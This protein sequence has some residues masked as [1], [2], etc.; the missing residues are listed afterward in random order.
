[1]VITPSP[2]IPMASSGNGLPAASIPMVRLS[3]LLPCASSSSFSASTSVARWLPGVAFHGAENC[4]SSPGLSCNPHSCSGCPSSS[5]VAVPVSRSPPALTTVASNFPCFPGSREPGKQGKFEATVVNAGGDLLTGTATLELDGQPLQ[6]WG[7]QLNPGEEAQFSAPWKAT[8]G[9][10]RATLVLALNE[11][12]LAQGNNQLNLT[13]GIDAAGSPLP[14]LAIGIVGLGVITIAAT[15]LLYRRRPPREPP[16][17]P[18]AP[19]PE[20]VEAVVVDDST[21]RR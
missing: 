2:T 13:I 19:A 7:L 6:E 17:L 11:E 8:P 21:W 16:A 5:S 10:H 15:F 9:S 14:L 4:A 20:P 12:E 18:E 3:W 1:M